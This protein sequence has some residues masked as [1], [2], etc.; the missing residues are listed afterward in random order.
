MFGIFREPLIHQEMDVEAT[1]TRGT[2]GRW[3][4]SALLLALTVEASQL[5]AEPPVNANSPTLPDLSR[6]TPSGLALKI[7]TPK[8]AVQRGRTHLTRSASKACLR[9]ANP[10][11]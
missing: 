1:S 10:A 4:S 9:Q 11:P 3:T 5:P 6:R 8:P 2:V 7:K